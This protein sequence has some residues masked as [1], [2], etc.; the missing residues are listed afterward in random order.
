MPSSARKK[1]K[2]RRKD[3]DSSRASQIRLLVSPSRSSTTLL[4]LCC[5]AR[6]PPLTHHS[7]PTRRSS[8]LNLVLELE[9]RDVGAGRSYGAIHVQ[10]DDLAAV[11]RAVHQFVPRLP[12]ERKSTRLNSSHLVISYAVFC[13]KKKKKKTK[14]RRLIESQSDQT[15]RFSVSL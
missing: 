13:T 3:E 6:S 4:A 12:G 8:D 14:R 10:T 11:E 1:K 2:K 9:V 15:T 7:F 5:S